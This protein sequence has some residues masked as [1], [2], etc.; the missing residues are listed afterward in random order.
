MQCWRHRSM[1]R[2]KHMNFGRA[3]QGLICQLASFTSYVH[4][5]SQVTKLSSLLFFPFLEG[6]GNKEYAIPCD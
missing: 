4:Q 1:C 6:H 5:S 3:I 2:S